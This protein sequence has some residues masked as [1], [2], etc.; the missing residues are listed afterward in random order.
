[1][2][3]RAFFWLAALNG[4]TGSNNWALTS[5]CFDDPK[6]IYYRF[7]KLQDGN[8]KF[9]PRG[10]GYD[11]TF[12]WPGPTGPVE[13]LRLKTHRD[14]VEDYE[15]YV[16]LRDLLKR[17]ATKHFL[18]DDMRKNG[19]DIFRNTVSKFAKS[20]GNISRNSDDFFTARQQLIRFI[21]DALKQE[22]AKK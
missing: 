7:E 11:A 9:T 21:E 2:P 5:W 16:I 10:A 22:R 20:V 4:V 17:D 6:Y 19:T 8:F 3:R 14:G 18:S 13:S 1:M 12:F 15:L